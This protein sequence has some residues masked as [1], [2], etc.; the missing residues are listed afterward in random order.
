MNGRH[1]L[2]YVTGCA[3]LAASAFGQQDRAVPRSGGGGS[4][5]AASA[6]RPFGPLLGPQQREQHPVDGLPLDAL[7]GHDDRGAPAPARRH[8]T[9][10]R[11]WLL[12]ESP[13]LPG[14]PGVGRGLGRLLP[15]VLGVLV[16]LRLR[17]L[18]WAGYWGAPW[19]AGA[20][21]SYAQPDR[22]AIRVLVD[23]ADTRVYVDG[24]YAG[25]VD[26]F[27][28]LF[29]RLHLAPGRHEISLKLGGYKTHRVRVYVGSGST[30]KLDH[31]M[32][33]GAG[34]TFEDL[35]RTARPREAAVRRRPSS[36]T[37]HARRLPRRR[38][39]AGCSSSS[40][41]GCLGLRRRG[42]PG[43][44]PRG[45][46]PRPLAGVA[47]GRG[48]APGLPH[49][50]ARR[51]GRPAGTSRSSRSSCSVP[52]AAA[53]RAPRGGPRRGIR[54]GP[55]CRGAGRIEWALLE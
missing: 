27:D 41:P 24:Y 18:G 3:F 28:G 52:E 10:Q 38:P 50:R 14:L 23:P 47:P 6:P 5:A 11:R 30:L 44:R 34:E 26:D 13:D 21:Y 29:Q 40:A 22:G 53:G 35:A 8:G 9:G 1:T 4:S 51:R 25:V 39:R 20:V 54:S 17:R 49:R 36:P 33:E 45:G 37:A 7:A 16:A 31:E 19:G 32:E 55:L 46:G 15:C 2:L 43:H 48:G 42:V 12:P